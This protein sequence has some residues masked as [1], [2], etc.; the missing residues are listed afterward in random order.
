MS[1]CF[2]Y[3]CV[4]FHSQL[5]N[6]FSLLQSEEISTVI[7]SSQQAFFDSILWC[8][9][10]PQS[11]WSE[12]QTQDIPSSSSPSS[13]LHVPILDRAEM[14]EKLTGSQHIPQSQHLLYWV[15]TKRQSMQLRNDSSMGTVEADQHSIAEF[16]ASYFRLTLPC[17][18]WARCPL[19]ERLGAPLVYLSWVSFMLQK[20]TLRTSRT[21]VH[22]MRDYLKSSL[23]T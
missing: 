9:G 13:S 6:H 12:E 8:F 7:F 14:P 22:W 15:E 1:G 2:L 20:S 4:Y 5:L 19:A 16:W 21:T 10:L 17:C 11:Q 3:V 23:L 18:E